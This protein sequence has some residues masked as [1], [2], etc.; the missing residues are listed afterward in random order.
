MGGNRGWEW[1]WEGIMRRQR[2]HEKKKG[3]GEGGV[4]FV[5]RGEV[6]LLYAFIY[7]I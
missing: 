2:K 5:Y 3:G 1:E 4:K 6:L 7:F